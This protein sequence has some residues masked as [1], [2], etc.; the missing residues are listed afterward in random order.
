VTPHVVG[1]RVVEPFAKVGAALGALCPLLIVHTAGLRLVQTPTQN[2]VFVANVADGSTHAPVTDAE[3]SIPELARSARTNWIGEA[4]IEAVPNG[5]YR[6]L[7]RRIGYA[8]AD[9]TI[10]F[11]QDTV[12]FVFFLAPAPAVLDTVTTTAKP[13]VPDR[14]RD[15]EFRRKMGIGRFLT[16]SMLRSEPIQPLTGI[17]ARRFPGIHSVGDGRTVARYNC[18]KVDVYID[19]FPTSP[20]VKAPDATDLRFIFGDNVAAVEYYTAAS[21]PVQYRPKHSLGCG[22]LLIW[23]RY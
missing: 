20:A 15:F 1:G 18:G 16:D 23:L 14:L 10:R 11:S 19:G 6:V 3:V 12:G 9:V 5:S 21:A 17:L 13:S 8:A 22:V 2:S 4:H 7:V